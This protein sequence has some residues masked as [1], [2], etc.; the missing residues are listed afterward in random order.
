MK[1]DPGPHTLFTTVGEM[2]PR[3]KM[4]KGVNVRLDKFRLGRE[5]GRDGGREA[6]SN[7]E[8]KQQLKI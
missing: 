5:G 8:F 4:K 2:I 1:F 7:I 6:L 3:R